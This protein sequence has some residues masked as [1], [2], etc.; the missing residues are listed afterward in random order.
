MDDIES[1]GRSYEFGLATRH[2][3]KHRLSSMAAAAR[4][5]LGMLSRD[6]MN[7]APQRI[8]GLDQ[9]QAILERAKEMEAEL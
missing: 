5:G 4:L 1:Y 3:L 9:L 2:H 8:E 6:R 7:L